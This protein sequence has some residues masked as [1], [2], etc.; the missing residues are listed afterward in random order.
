MF[1]LL[2]DTCVWLDLAKD[3]RQDALLAAVEE[4]VQRGS[5]VLIVP[6][7]VIAE[8]A[9]NK[10]RIGEDGAR[11]LSSTLK[12]AREIV[13]TLGEGKGKRLALEHI[14]E[15]DHKLPRLGEA[16]VASLGRIESLFRDAEVVEMSDS[17]VLR[18]A[19]RGIDGRAPFHRQRNGMGDAILIESYADAVSAD[20]AP[21]TRFAFVTHNI[22]DFSQA[23]GDTRVPHPDIAGLFSKI[24]SLYMTSL[25]ETVRRID[26]GIVTEVMFEREFEQEPRRL[27]EILAALSELLDKVW[28]NRHQVLRE[29]I[30]DGVVQIVEKETFPVADHAKRPIQRDV[31][32]GALRSAKKMEAKYGAKNLGPWSDFEWGMRNGKLSALRWVLGEDWDNLD[33]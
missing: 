3:H 19:Q 9:R 4:L 14:A 18:A 17:I 26:A 31:W 11:S 13:T 24:R 2:I 25:V 16:A 27:A 15:L 21:R 7:I 5:A 28:Y 23:V 22:K 6:R 12:R 30:E 20:A 29:R 8:F 33:M 10:K 1:K 32:E